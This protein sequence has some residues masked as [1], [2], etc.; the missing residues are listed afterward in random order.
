MTTKTKIDRD[1]N[2][3]AR[4]LIEGLDA[5][6]EEADRFTKAAKAA[7]RV[8]NDPG[9]GSVAYYGSK[10][11]AAARRASLDLSAALSAYRNLYRPKPWPRS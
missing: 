4:E 2:S 6:I 1:V 8:L 9:E 3:R 11:T 10:P 7:I 5:A